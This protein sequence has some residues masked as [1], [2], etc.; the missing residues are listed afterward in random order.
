MRVPI[1]WLREYVDLPRDT[2]EI[3]HR[4]AMLGFPVEDVV[5]RPKITGVV[6]GKIVRL[7]KHPNADRLQVGTIDVGNEKPLTIATAATNV[8]AGQVIPVATIGARLPQLTI[9][10]RKMRGIASEG[11]MVSADELALP[12][13]WFEDGIMQLEPNAKIGGHVV[14]AYGLDDDVLEVEVTSNRVD[15]MSVIGL[16]RELA[17]SYGVE[18]RLPPA[19]NP[20]TRDEP[21]GHAVDVAIESPDCR[22]FVAQRFDGI[23]AGPA[24]AWMRIKLALA[25][26]R[27][28]GK[29]VDVSNYVMLETG[30]PLHF[31]DAKKIS[32]DRL[33]VRDGR[34]GEKT[35]TLD[36]VERTL[37]AQSLVIADDRQTL[38]LAGLMGAAAGEVDDSTT[39]IVLEAANFNGA[40]VRRM[41]K[42]LGLRSEASSR[43]EKSLPLALTDAGAARAAQLLVELGATAYRPHAF[44]D[45]IE[46]QPRIELKLSDVKRLLGID[47]PGD[48]VAAHLRSLGCSVERRDGMVDV[49]PP[50][51]RN[52][53]TIPA[54]A[55]EEI[56]RVEGYENIPA[57]EPSVPAHDISSAQYALENRVAAELDALGYY[58]IVTYSLV[59]R[60]W[61]DSVE[62]LDPLS[63]D[64]R[65]L[66]TS[67]L[68]AMLEYFAKYDAPVRVFEAGHTFRSENGHIVESAVVTFGFTSEPA[69]D[70]EWYDSAFLRLKGDAEALLRRVTGRDAEV[71]RDVR[72]GFHLGKTG[73]LIVDGHEVAQ[74]GRLDPRNTAAA[75]VR[76]PAYACTVLLDRLPEYRIPQYVPP[77][78][79]P[80]TYRDLALEVDLELTAA[81]VE[82]SVAETLGQMCT[83]VR[84]FDEYRGPQVRTGQ[85][86]L[87]VRITLQRFDGTITDEEADSAIER[88]LVA[89][90]ERGAVIRQ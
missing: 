48:R 86:S 39:G 74:L 41:S 3:A 27:P 58:E 28:I 51:W 50:P 85:K 45:A 17:A 11:M 54:D 80:S 33:I 60:R 1:S 12:S 88:V 76:L 5:R 68:P 40:R 63:E 26:Q 18:L 4:L 13:E 89:L 73:V 65:Y 84:V 64:Q 43:H 75:G 77:P 6:V 10:P 31:Y 8:A 56:A 29:L 37:S 19:P 71:S 70:P 15:A 49:T 42:A 62:V 20:G 34:E 46:P 52:D 36:D 57:V 67:I 90:R 47:I 69:G 7:E 82:R 21:A 16:A 22:R 30:Q 59:G 53:L 9:E 14:A 87:A 2:D 83:G 23:T 24:P 25:G 79:F 81:D 72:E 66:R 44:G 55:I 38:C 61:A 78:K 32:G 35:V